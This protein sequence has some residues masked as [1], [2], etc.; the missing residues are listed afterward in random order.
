MY[1][2]AIRNVNIFAHTNL[3]YLYE[4]WS[5]CEQAFLVIIF[6][7]W[8]AIKIAK[9]VRVQLTQTEK[10]RIVCAVWLHPFVSRS[11][12][13]GSTFIKLHASGICYMNEIVKEMSSKKNEI[14]VYVRIY[15][16]T[17]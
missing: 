5:T 4:N 3:L 10:P 2:N 15:Q 12:N 16:N 13:L 1:K 7:I 17:N 11:I 6:F 14:V 9:M 8:S